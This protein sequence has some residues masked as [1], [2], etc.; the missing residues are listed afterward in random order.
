M[1]MAGGLEIAQNLLTRCWISTHDEDKE[2]SGVSVRSVVTRKH[3]VAEVRARVEE[4][5]R[6][7]GRVGL[8]VLMLDCGKE[9]QLSV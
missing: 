5:R 1:G 3:T 9:V 6:K 2:S 4:D 8:E 7:G